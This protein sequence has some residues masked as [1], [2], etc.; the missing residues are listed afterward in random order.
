MAEKSKLRKRVRTHPH[1]GVARKSKILP[2]AVSVFY[3]YK[4]DSGLSL[5]HDSSGGLAQTARNQGGDL[6]PRGR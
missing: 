2:L 4:L 6:T 5:C 3:V 1:N